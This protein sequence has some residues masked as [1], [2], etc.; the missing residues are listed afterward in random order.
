MNAFVFIGLLATTVPTP[1]TADSGSQS[2]C[3]PRDQRGEILLARAS[4]VVSSVDPTI[5]QNRQNIW[6]IPPLSSSQVTWISD[7]SLC[8]QAVLAFNREVP[9]GAFREQRVYVIQLGADYLVVHPKE[10]RGEWMAALVFHS[11]FAKVSPQV[12]G[13]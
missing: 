10:R 8:H 7:E 11:A 12:F 4:D 5:S 9:T 2:Y 13:L 6:A 1:T 3:M